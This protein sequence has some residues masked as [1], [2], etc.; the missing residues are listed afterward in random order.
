ML[1]SIHFL[2]PTKL[3]TSFAISIVLDDSDSDGR[4]MN[5]VIDLVRNA[6]F[7]NSFKIFPNSLWIYDI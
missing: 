3:K 2:V 6:N 1:D 7:F 4:A 5:E